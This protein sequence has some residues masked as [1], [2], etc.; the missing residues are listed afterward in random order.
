MG[1]RLFALISIVAVMGAH[2]GYRDTHG[3]TWWEWFTKLTHNPIPVLVPFLNVDINKL[4]RNWYQL[5]ATAYFLLAVIYSSSSS[6][7]E[8][9]NSLPL[10]ISFGRRLTFVLFELSF[11]TCICVIVIY[12]SVLFIP[13]IDSIPNLIFDIFV[14]GIIGVWLL[15]ELFL[16]RITF[17]WTHL[18]WELFAIASYLVFNYFFTVNV[19]PIYS[20]VTYKDNK[21]TEV[22]VGAIILA[23]GG[24]AFGYALTLLRDYCCGGGKD[25]YQDMTYAP[26]AAIPIRESS[27]L[28]SSHPHEQDRPEGSD[29]KTIE[30]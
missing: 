11:S 12:W 19:E 25:K 10:S 24:F 8:E 3:D 26:T 7:S 1:F 4:K 18:L 23:I 21:S 6:H 9:M 27:E 29:E 13:V 30:L 17:V 5:L 28:S 2:I 16:N 14:H 22:V 20:L 15:L